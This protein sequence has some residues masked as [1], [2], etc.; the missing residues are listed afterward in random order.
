[1]N[2]DEDRDV[3][4]QHFQQ[5]L[6][7]YGEFLNETDLIFAFFVKCNNEFYDSVTFKRISM[8]YLG[9]IWTE[10]HVKSCTPHK[11]NRRVSSILSTNYFTGSYALR[12]VFD[13]PHYIFWETDDKENKNE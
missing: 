10:F 8:D 9:E 4:G 11:Q 13:G 12:Y 2:G 7:W 1:M 5:L 3:G 6:R